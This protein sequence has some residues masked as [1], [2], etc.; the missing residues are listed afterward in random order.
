MLIMIIKVNGAI[1]N[2]EPAVANAMPGLIGGKRS[3]RQEHPEQ[4]KTVCRVYWAM[5][6]LDHAGAHQYQ[7]R[8]EKNEPDMFKRD[9]F[10]MRNHRQFSCQFESAPQSRSHFT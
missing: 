2:G 6:R 7:G 5:I 4:R 1:V 10:G 9:I 8:E 3:G